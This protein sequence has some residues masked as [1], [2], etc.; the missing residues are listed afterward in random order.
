MSRIIQAFPFKNEIKNMK[1]HDLGY[2]PGEEKYIWNL[3]MNPQ[4]V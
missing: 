4:L 2:W 1:I 3:L